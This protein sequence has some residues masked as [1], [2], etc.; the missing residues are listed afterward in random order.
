MHKQDAKPFYVYII[1]DP[2]PRKANVPIYVGKG[3]GKRAFQHFSPSRNVGSALN[4]IIAKCRAISL[5]PPIK[6][7]RRFA[8]EKDAFKLEI[9]LIAK[10]GR[11]D[12][13]TGTLCNLTDGG[14]GAAGWI[15]PK[16]WRANTSARIKALHEAKP[17]WRDQITTG[18]HKWW[19][20]PKTQKRHSKR[21]REEM[22]KPER[23]EQISALGKTLGA[24]PKIRLQRQAIMRKLNS[25]PELIQLK[26]ARLSKIARNPIFQRLLHKKHRVWIDKP[27]TRLKL[28]DN[29]K[30]NKKAI[31]KAVNDYW[32]DPKN[33]AKQAERMRKKNADPKFQALAR[34]GRNMT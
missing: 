19:A 33:R 5:K 4:R 22:R 3:K 26:R 23:I 20:N 8:K 16:N 1:R 27:E 21:M 31:L 2:R 13:G 15:P 10:Y 29:Y 30:K 32:S 18:W 7:I 12:L 28:R 14:D 24:D 6:I 17:E 11:R 34:A 9:A 25:D